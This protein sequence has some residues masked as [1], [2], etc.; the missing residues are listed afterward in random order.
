M[1][2]HETS[3]RGRVWSVSCSDRY[4]A[5]MPGSRQQIALMRSGCGRHIAASGAP[6]ND[7]QSNRFAFTDFGLQGF[8]SQG[9]PHCFLTAP[10]LCSRDLA[11]HQSTVYLQESFRNALFARTSEC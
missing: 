10:L 1:T 2:L 5:G 9:V 6:A 4:S 3:V 8:P 11:P 7:A